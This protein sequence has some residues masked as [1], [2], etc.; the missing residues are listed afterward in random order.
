MRDEKFV[1]VN[2]E[3][4][5][6]VYRAVLKAKNLLASGEASSA[7]QAAKMA[8][9]SRGAYYKYKDAI[10]EYRQSTDGETITM[11]A[12]LLDNPGVLTAMLSS[13][14]QEGANILSVNQNIPVN[15]VAS[16]SVT[17]RVDKDTDLN[18]LLDRVRNIVGVKSVEEIK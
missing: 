4:L 9:I 14:Y 7:S 17:V 5:P 11:F 13:L 2:S 8:G 16:V 15:N 12:N 6:E 10:F 1:L 18:A 3:K